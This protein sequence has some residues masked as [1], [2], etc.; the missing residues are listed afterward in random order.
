MGKKL[1]LGFIGLIIVGAIY[2]FMAGSQQLTVQMKKQ[3]NTELT[4]I[5]KEGFS[6]ENRD[7]QKEKEHFVLSFDDTNKIAKFLTRQGLQLNVNDASFLKGFKLGI[8][9]NYLADAY[10]AVAFDIY[11]LALPSLILS[12]AEDDKEKAILQKLLDKKTFLAHIA[13]NKLGTGFKGNMKDINEVLHGKQNV[14][15]KMQGLTFSGDIK[16]QRIS[17][18]KEE[19]S[20][21][22]LLVDDDVAFTFSGVKSDYLITGKTPYDYRMN[23]S[24]D[25][26]QA[27]ASS[28]FNLLANDIVMHSD[29]TVKNGLASGS[30]QAKTKSMQVT[31]KAKTYLF[32]TFAFKTHAKGLDISAFEKLQEINV[33]NEQEVNALLQQMMSKGVSFEIPTFSVQNIEAEGQ[34]LNGFDIT[35]HVNL[36]KSFDITALQVNPMSALSSVD[37]NLHLSLSKELFGLVAQVPQAM[38]ALMLFQPKDE[39]GKK[40]YNLELKDSK[41]TVNGMPVN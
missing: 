40:V 31:T 13:V 20:T 19:V 17:S 34:K 30:M 35:A 27:H 29:S 38:M 39:N 9:V 12:I 16:A 36:D 41:F 22:S 18:I 1:G 8:D 21:L 37:A 26:M 2:Y 25:K 6:V 5:Q 32:D 14:T 11:P 15:L 10:S 4:S 7:I 33:N 28:K 24:I 3:V 23:Y